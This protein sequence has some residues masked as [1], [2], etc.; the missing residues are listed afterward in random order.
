MARAVHVSGSPPRVLVLAD[1]FQ[2]SL[3]LVRGLRAGGFE[4]VAT[5]SGPHPYV[6]YSRAVSA[7][8]VV[9]D[10]H[11]APDE[12]TAAVAGAARELG[13][14][15]IL[16]GYEAALLTLASRRQQLPVSLAAPDEQVVRLA[17][18][19]DRVLGLAAE[20]GLMGPP[21]T[22][23][24]PPALAEQADEFTYPVILKPQRSRL[25]LPDERLIHFNA[26][27]IGSAQSLREALSGL[28]GSGWVVQPY[29]EGPLSAVAGVAWEGRVVAA[30]H[31]VS[32]RTWPPEVGF[33]SYAKTVERDAELEAR[34]VELV[35]RLRWSGIFQAQMIV[36]DDG[37]R[38]LIDF[39]PRAY[40]SLALALGAGAN[41]PALW[42]ALA[43]GATPGP[44]SY[45]PG[46]RYRLEHNDVRA[47]IALL[48][49]RRLG[50]AGAAMLPRRRT[51]HGV[52][53]LRDPW[54]AVAM[55]R[56]FTSWAGRSAGPDPAA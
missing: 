23:A 55:L 30:V 48:R 9:P 5:V 2:A 1:D 29:I 16:P 11:L 46:V 4:P 3:A 36:A 8:R 14:R 50:A 49:R 38:L 53:S 19:K 27:R 44:V 32:L 34:I 28:P 22:V 31:Q 26:R 56:K 21:S 13:A 20:L 43:L 18:D 6:R 12:F 35:A 10:P 47:I 15:I 45:R 33:S 40:G 7:V 25:E 39:N 52:F 42:A 17:T 37:R 51:V 54:P 41:L 24:D